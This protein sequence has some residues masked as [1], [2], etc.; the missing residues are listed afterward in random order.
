[1]KL[2]LIFYLIFSVESTAIFC[3]FKEESF[4]YQ[5]SVKYMKITSK[6]EQNITGVF[7]D[8]KSGKSNDDVINFKSEDHVANYFPHNL[9]NFFKNLQIIQIN[10]ASLTEIHN[11]DLK[12]LGSKLTKFEALNNSIK[13]LE[14]DLF[15]NNPNLEIIDLSNNKINHIDDGVFTSLKNLKNLKLEGNSCINEK[16]VDLVFEAETKCKNFSFMLR[17]INEEFQAQLDVRDKKL[18][19]EMDKKMEKKWTQFLE[20]KK[21]KEKSKSDKVI[22]HAWGNDYIG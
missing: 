3:D 10:N 20:E 8:H 4:G 12:E 13:I 1:M 9:T 7:G 11:L 19:N 6:N 5:C 22:H 16:S 2:I 18:I 15:K 17:R 21:P 14:F